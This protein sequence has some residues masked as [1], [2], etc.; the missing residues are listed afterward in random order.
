ME[1]LN[2]VELLKD[3]PRGTWL[4]SSIYGSVRFEGLKADTVAFPILVRRANG[5]LVELTKEGKYTLGC[6][7][8]CVL[9]PSRENRDWSNFKANFDTDMYR[10]GEYVKSKES[11]RFF[12]ITEIR[13]GRWYTLYDIVTQYEGS[14][15]TK[16]TDDLHEKLLCCIQV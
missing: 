11:E 8:E 15:I 12:K 14:H 10:V 2:L 3:A 6:D 9:F 7:S 16:S 13:N 4:Y 1:N 5:A